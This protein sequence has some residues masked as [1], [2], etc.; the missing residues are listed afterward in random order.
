MCFGQSAMRR[1]VVMRGPAIEIAPAGME[2]SQASAQADDQPQLLRC[3]LGRSYAPSMSR[4]NE[5]QC[6]VS[7]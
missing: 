4:V 2:P 7:W 3:D 5:R 6:G 1:M